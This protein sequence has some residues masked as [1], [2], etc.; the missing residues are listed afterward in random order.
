MPGPVPGFG[1]QHGGR[2]SFWSVEV[3][4]DLG[5]G[6]RMVLTESDRLAGHEKVVEERAVTRV[7][8]LL[9]LGYYKPIAV[10]DLTGTILDGY[11]KTAA[12]GRI[13]LDL[14]AVLPVDYLSDEQITGAVWSKS[15]RASITMADVLEM[16]ASGE[17]F[18]AKTFRRV[19]PFAPP[20]LAVPLGRLGRPNGTP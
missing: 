3:Q 19:M 16:A 17:G 7:E 5:A 13:G 1:A 6:L 8:E 15:G 10:D 2:P 20:Q 12:A 4:T 9:K 18:S 11:Q 14:L